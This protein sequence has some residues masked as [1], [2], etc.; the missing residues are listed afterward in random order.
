MTKKSKKSTLKIPIK[1]SG[2]LRLEPDKILSKNLPHL[3]KRM[4]M[5]KK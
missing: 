4:R 2:D 3:Q 1:F 5:P